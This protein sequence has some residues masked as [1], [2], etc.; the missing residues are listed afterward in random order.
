MFEPREDGGERLLEGG[1]DDGFESFQSVLCGEW[2]VL[3]ISSG[4]L[5][6]NRPIYGHTIQ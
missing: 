6:R 5:C 2:G 1:N 4:D 3:M